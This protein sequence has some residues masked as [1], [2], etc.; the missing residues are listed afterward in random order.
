MSLLGA[1]ILVPN[2]VIIGFFSFVLPNPEFNNV[3]MYRFY[4]R[5]NL[6]QRGHTFVVNCAIRQGRE[7]NR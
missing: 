2:T 3:C 1:G 4:R 6:A 5:L 7:K